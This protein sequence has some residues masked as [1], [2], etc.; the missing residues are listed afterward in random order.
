M[1][2]AKLQSYNDSS[3]LCA[4][5]TLVSTRS[6]QPKITSISLRY[7]GELNTEPFSQVCDK[8]PDSDLY[9]ASFHSLPSSNKGSLH[10]TESKHPT[11]FR[12]N[13]PS[14][15]TSSKSFNKSLFTQQ[16]VNSDLSKSVFTQKQKDL[17]SSFIESPFQLER[18]SS[19]FRTDEINYNNLNPRSSAGKNSDCS[20]PYQTS[21]LLGRKVRHPEI[22]DKFMVYYNQNK[23]EFSSK[24][25]SEQELEPIV[26]SDN[27]IS[28]NR[29][30]LSPVTNKTLQKD[31]ENKKCHALVPKS[32]SSNSSELIRSRRSS[33]KD[34]KKEQLSAR[35]KEMD[36]ECHFYTGTLSSEKHKHLEGTLMCES[37]KETDIGAHCN[38]REKTANKLKSNISVSTKHDRPLSPSRIVYS[39][40]DL[41]CRKVV[42]SPVYENLKMVA[43][44]STKKQY[45][46]NL[47]N[48]TVETESAILEELTRA[49]DQILQAVN[50]YTDEESY[51]ASS[52]EPDDEIVKDGR[53]RRGN[54]CGQM[55]RPLA[56]LGTITEAPSSKK[57]RETGNSTSE[58]HSHK[59]NSSA[60]KGQRLT[61]MRPCP[62]SSTSSMESF[63]RENSRMQTR[64][65][66]KQEGSGSVGECNRGKVASSSTSSTAIKSSNRTA[67]FLQRASSRELLLQTYASSSEDVASGVEVGSNRKPMVPRR[68][69]THNSSNNKTDPAKTNIKKSTISSDSQPSLSVKVRPRKRDVDINKPKER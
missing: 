43:A 12:V 59:S 23:H 44:E 21:S 68:T 54:R 65:L 17:S 26:L 37:E 69:R 35:E 29:M 24:C 55:Q 22:E 45:D 30:S 1:T 10:I 4:V 34:M 61:K 28:S 36:K 13:T 11:D 38:E 18:Q 41:S 8:N 58:V 39:Q 20:S 62:A 66:L 31:Q 3:R 51:R 7:E 32:G 5:E 60:R 33:G 56:S 25:N 47:I 53:R 48:D 2:E 46:Q 57:Q 16:K 15:V 63:T 42:T 19:Q 64:P 14:T 27:K 6:G 67:R 52:D 50:G 49:A 9:Q 40:T